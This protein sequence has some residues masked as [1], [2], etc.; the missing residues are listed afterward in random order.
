MTLQLA[1]AENEYHSCVCFEELQANYD[2]HPGS[3]ATTNNLKVTSEQIIVFQAFRECKLIFLYRYARI[4]LELSFDCVQPFYVPR[5]AFDIT[6]LSKTVA[7]AGD[8][9]ITIVDPMKY[10]PSSRLAWSLLMCRLFLVCLVAQ[11]LP[12]Q[13]SHL[14]LQTRELQT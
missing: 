4:T 9:G 11:F 6:L 14:L 8:K 5:N 3:A 12:C 10:V 7:V 13:T 2:S 1:I